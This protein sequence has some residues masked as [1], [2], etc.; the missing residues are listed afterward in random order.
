MR[1]G[2]VWLDIEQSHFDHI[3]IRPIWCLL[4]I[5]G[6][7]APFHL[8]NDCVTKFVC[9]CCLCGAIRVLLLAIGNTDINGIS[10]ELIP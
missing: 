1:G 6:C 4:D 9:E 5:R 10:F 8:A 7:K 3:W 2:V